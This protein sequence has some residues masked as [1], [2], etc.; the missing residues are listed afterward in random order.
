MAEF[1]VNSSRLEATLG[2]RDDHRE[3]PVAGEL[4]CVNKADCKEPSR[5]VTPRPQAP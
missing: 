1:S 3:G 5:K 4:V 2:T